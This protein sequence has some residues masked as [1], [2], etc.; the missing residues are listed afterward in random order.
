MKLTPLVTLLIA[1]AATFARA[2]H[3]AAVP[4]APTIS[5]A[6]AAR[7]PAGGILV[8][9][10]TDHDSTGGPDAFVISR[11]T[12]TGLVEV[13]REAG[14]SV[15]G[16]AW[17]DARTLFVFDTGETT[18]KLRTF[19]DGKLDPSRGREIALADWQLPA[20]KAPS[21]LM[22]VLGLA[23]GGA[24]WFSQCL[25]HAEDSDRCLRWTYL[26]VDQPALTTARKRPAGLVDVRGQLGDAGAGTAPLPRLGKA[27][28]GVV[29]ALKK[30]KIADP[31]RPDATRVK[32]FT[33]TTGGATVS[34][35]SPEV[36]DWTFD[37]R[38]D[39]IQWLTATP[40]LFFV[41]GK[42]T[43]PVGQVTRERRYFRACAPGAFEDFRWLGEGMWA[44]MQRVWTNDHYVDSAW[45]VY[46]DADPV[47]VIIGSASWFEFAPR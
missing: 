12:R 33:C 5:P 18:I 26:R 1:A 19:V 34:W 25:A 24:I 9:A 11:L 13:F 39:K 29:V 21:L 8:A 6:A 31:D 45:T 28:A 46:V 27:P 22:P 37:I 2:D 14:S 43:N 15:S 32:G 7:L 17:L 4:P 16:F 23:K 42:A 40:P 10:Q 44:E 41:E 3:L 38:P 35:P 30:V 20:G 47:A 36:S